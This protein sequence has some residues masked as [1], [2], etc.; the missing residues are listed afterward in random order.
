MMM[1]IFN[2][3]A[4]VLIL[5]VGFAL[6]RMK[7]ETQ[8]LQNRVDQLNRQIAEDQSETKVLNAEWAYLSNPQRLQRLASR[9]LDL[10]P[11]GPKQMLL[12]VA[13]IQPRPDDEG[14]VLRV[15]D[16]ERALPVGRHVAAVKVA[17]AERPVQRHLSEKPA[18]LHTKLVPPVTRRPFNP[19]TDHIRL[20]SSDGDQ[21][22]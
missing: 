3:L 6:Y 8:Q 15:V 17:R 11:A 21:R 16:F 9:Y 22:P 10:Q 4:V 12:T 18:V 14:K 5:I 13:N 19:A 7:F 1:R 20:V 2:L